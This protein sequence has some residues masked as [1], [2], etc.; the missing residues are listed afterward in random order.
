[1]DTATQ[2]QILDETDCISHSTN[3]LG[4]GMHQIILPP[5]MGKIVG[6]ARFFS[7]GEASSLGEGKL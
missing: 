2:V 1:M 3:T 4:E 5:A 7:L 6:Q